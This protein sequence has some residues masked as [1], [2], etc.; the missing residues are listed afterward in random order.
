M[1]WNDTIS[2]EIASGLLYDKKNYLLNN[3]KM[4]K[5]G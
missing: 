4:A 5:L 3:E 1:I 2:Y